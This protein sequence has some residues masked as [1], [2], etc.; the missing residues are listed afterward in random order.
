MAGRSGKSR[1]PARALSIERIV[2]EGLLI[3]LSAV[4]MAVKNRIIIGALRD[5][6]D[7]DAADYPAIARHELDRLAR[8]NEAD[9]RRVTRARKQLL[10]LRWTEAPDDDRRG[11]IA[12]LVLRRRVYVA[13]ARALHAVSGDA[14]KVAELVETARTDASHEIGEALTV[15]LIEQA[16]D[17]AEPDYLVFRGERME[18]LAGDLAALLAPPLSGAEP[19]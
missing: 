6:D 2:D 12:Q 5:H 10:K 9:A 16:F 15:R 8:Q 14:Q 7:F 18:A 17:G 4:R 19:P 11:D 1:V 13:L 3:G